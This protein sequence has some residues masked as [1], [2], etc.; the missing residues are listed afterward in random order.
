MPLCPKCGGIEWEVT[1]LPAPSGGYSD[2]L[3]TAFRQRRTGRVATIPGRYGIRW[4][5]EV[6][7]YSKTHKG[8]PW[9]VD[10]RGGPALL[11]IRKSSGF[12]P[13]VSEA[14]TQAERA[15]HDL[16]HGP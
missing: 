5:L 1:A 10:Y 15:Y 11:D 12:A 14:K 8:Y 9:F 4:S 16:A 6:G 7:G 3:R 2:N 13:T